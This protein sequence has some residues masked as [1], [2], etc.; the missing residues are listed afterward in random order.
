MI[1]VDDDGP[2]IPQED[3]DRIFEAFSRLDE[4]RDRQS[5]G[6]GLGLA[7][8]K[9]IIEAHKGKI[10]VGTSPS[11]GARFTITWP[12]KNQFIRFFVL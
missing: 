4:S 10:S 9:R 6:H 1:H 3:R 8:A 11:G 7:I 12:E 2:G 5:G